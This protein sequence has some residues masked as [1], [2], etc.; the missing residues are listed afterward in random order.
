MGEHYGLFVA[1]GMHRLVDQRR[2]GVV[3]ET[4]DGGLHGIHTQPYIWDA[5]S[6]F[7]IRIQAMMGVILPGCEGV[8]N[9]WGLC[10]RVRVY[11]LG[12]TTSLDA[13]KE[14]TEA[15]PATESNGGQL[16]DDMVSG[17]ACHRC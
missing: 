17:I 5:E 7:V 2:R 12:T 6:C 11:Q 9:S 16:R 10:L 1:F 14:L 15:I 4:T 3:E 13:L 8:S